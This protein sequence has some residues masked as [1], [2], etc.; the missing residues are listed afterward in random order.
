VLADLALRRSTEYVR[1]LADGP[2]LIGVHGPGSERELWVPH[3]DP[4]I[5]RLLEL[6][7]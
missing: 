3:D 6:A 2:A 4:D 5:N 7:T 1:Q